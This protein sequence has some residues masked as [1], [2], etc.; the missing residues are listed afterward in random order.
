[1]TALE[2]DH[3]QASYG[4][5]APTLRDVSLT[6]ADGEVV[7]VL[8][9][10]GA[11]K[12]T[13]LRA[14]SG[15]LA[16]E[17]GRVTHGD[18]RFAGRS[19]RGLDPGM[20]V[21]RG[22]VQVLEGRQVFRHLTVEQ[23]LLAGGHTAGSLRS[24]RA[25]AREMFELFPALAALRRSK[26]DNLSG[27]EQQLLAVARALMARP[28]LLILDEPSLGLAPIRAREIFALVA[29]VNRERGVTILLVEQNARAALA[30]A[31]RAYVLEAG[32]V[33][34]AGTPAELRADPR[35][36]AAYLGVAGE[37][38]YREMDGRPIGESPTYRSP[39]FR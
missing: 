18:L 29:R 33:V 7:A 4:S 37:N 19:I 20:I 28:R 10:N 38:A 12:T 34:L 23:N 6:V 25:A 27:G 36:S 3:V 35:V 32:T 11:G 24:A 30:L 21:R 1:M 39:T 31:D 22:I 16:G 14:V 26:A 8:G 17:R 5:L 15:L 13:M 9:P 2:L